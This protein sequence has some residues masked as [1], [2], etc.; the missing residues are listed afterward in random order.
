[1]Q[2]ILITGF[3]PFGNAT[4]NPSW[5]V[6]QAIAANLEHN[7]SILAVAAELA[8]SFGRGMEQLN[9]L[10][11]AHDPDLVICLGLAEG[12]P[13]LSV[14]RLAVNLIDAR[15]PDNDGSQP[16]DVPIISG[17]PSACLPCH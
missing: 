5:P 11:A 10:I 17:G 7:P 2:R 4:V 15:I 3:E 14:E 6:A 16:I 12:R 9:E 1:M 13:T 8:C